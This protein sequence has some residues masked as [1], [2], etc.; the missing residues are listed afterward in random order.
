MIKFETP[1]FTELLAVDDETYKRLNFGGIYKF[2][3]TSKNLLYI[4]KTKNFNSRIRSHFSGT[5]NTS[6]FIDEV[7][8]YSYAKIDSLAEQDIIETYLINK[9]MP[10]YN[11]YKTYFDLDVSTYNDYLKETFIDFT[12]RLIKANKGIEIG[13]ATLKYFCKLQNVEYLS[14]T[15]TY[16]KERLS[17]EG[18]YFQKNALVMR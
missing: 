5:S 18:I 11:F 17:Q 9:L 6:G 7:A 13:I 16:V 2:Y 14:V 10:K 8:Y 15:D 3:C 12:V 4:G 1:K